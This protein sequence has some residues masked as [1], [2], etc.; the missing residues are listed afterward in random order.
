MWIASLKHHIN[1]SVSIANEETIR[2]WEGEVVCSVSLNWHRSAVALA[3]SVVVG[4]RRV[5]S[6]TWS[7]GPEA[8]RDHHYVSIK[9]SRR[10]VFLRICSDSK[11]GRWVEAAV[12]GDKRRFDSLAISPVWMTCSS[13][14]PR[15]SCSARALSSPPRRYPQVLGPHSI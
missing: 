13:R 7:G 12:V 9:R 4:C 8:R 2:Y 5:S 1:R 3:R 6:S 11:T 14:I 15:S 10:A